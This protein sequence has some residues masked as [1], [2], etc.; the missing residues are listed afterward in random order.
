M[1]T[2][3]QTAEAGNRPQLHL[4]SRNDRERSRIVF[5][6][7]QAV[8]SVIAEIKAQ[9][10]AAKIDLTTTTRPQG[11]R[12][13]R[14]ADARPEERDRRIGKQMNE[15]HRKAINAVDAVRRK[16][17]QCAGRAARSGS[18]SRSTTGRTEQE[19]KQQRINDAAAEIDRQSI[20][21]RG[22]STADVDAMRKRVDA[23]EI[24]TRALRDAGRRPH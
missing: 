22:A 9:I 7:E 16:V 23:I 14:G 24:T 4:L 13:P 19:A 18:A 2:A 5:R 6:D 17:R 1:N 12:Q 8:D 11:D 3:P 15:E 10:D 20:C 21:S